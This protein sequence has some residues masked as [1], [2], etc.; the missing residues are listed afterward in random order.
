VLDDALR[1]AAEKLGSE[2]ITIDH[3]S[4]GAGGLTPQGE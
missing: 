3:K 2:L 1:G 4:M